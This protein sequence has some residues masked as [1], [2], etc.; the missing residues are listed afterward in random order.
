MGWVVVCGVGVCLGGVGE[1]G[2]GTQLIH[3]DTCTARWS[4]VVEAPSRH[5]LETY[6]VFF[7]TEEI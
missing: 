3:V 4:G 7:V 5:L 1:G 2:K 6:H